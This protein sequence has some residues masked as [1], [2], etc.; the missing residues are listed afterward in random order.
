VTAAQVVFDLAASRGLI[1]EMFR[2][3]ARCR[4][5]VGI[6]R[7]D[8]KA[9]EWFA[10]A[11]SK[12][13]KT[14]CSHSDTV[15]SSSR[16][17]IEW[18]K[19]TADSGNVDAM[20][21][22][23]KHYESRFGV[24]KDSETAAGWYERAA[25]NGHKEALFFLID[26]Y[27]NKNPAKRFNWL[28]RAVD[29]GHDAAKFD[30]AECYMTG[31]GV[32]RDASAAVSLYKELNE[33]SEDSAA[34]ELARYYSYG[35][36]VRDPQKAF[37]WYSRA[38]ES[39]S[40]NWDAYFAVAYCFLAGYGTTKNEDKGLD[41]CRDLGDWPVS[42]FCMAMHH[43]RVNEVE[44]A[45]ELLKLASE[46]GGACATFML[47]HGFTDSTD[48]ADDPV[49]SYAELMNLEIDSGGSEE[50]VPKALGLWHDRVNTARIGPL[51][52]NAWKLHDGLL[53]EPPVKGTVRK[54]VVDTQRI[55]VQADIAL[56]RR[57]DSYDIANV[58]KL[59]A[60]FL[61][62][63][64]AVDAKVSVLIEKSMEAADD[65]V[66][67]MRAVVMSIDTLTR[68]NPRPAFTTN[69][70]FF[71]QL[72]C[73][74]DDIDVL[75]ASGGRLIPC[76]RLLVPLVHALH[77][78]THIVELN[79]ELNAKFGTDFFYPTIEGANELRKRVMAALDVIDRSSITLASL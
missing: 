79:R 76:H 4:D 13:R 55:V 54:L 24:M 7:N 44:K 37:E 1:G 26:Y 21:L 15:R 48:E 2:L 57:L 35:H 58:N 68:C 30:L 61:A 43:V 39:T 77:T 64:L 25:E 28:Q 16:E 75:E 46:D 65:L 19:G 70:C 17:A 69:R 23:A 9:K 18:Y 67:T 45:K 5:G 52:K 73:E 47:K 32:M 53:V 50:S 27:K 34:W 29:N 33:S 72:V 12:D 42:R 41:L 51:G 66:R 60:A 59:T 36:G 78:L 40:E 6:E 10:L 63:Y 31:D 14:V 38:S 11:F 20:F 22:L 62:C 8:A 71:S 74:N 56:K 49:Q 3:A